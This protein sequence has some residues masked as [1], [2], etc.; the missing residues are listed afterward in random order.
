MMLSK[1][2]FITPLFVVSLLLTTSQSLAS[3]LDKQGSPQIT[4]QIIEIASSDQISKE[5][6]IG[7][8]LSQASGGFNGYIRL[9]WFDDN[10]SA[11]A[12]QIRHELIAKGIV[13][14][15]ITLAYTGGGYR[16]QQASGIQAHVQKIVLQ[17][18]ECRYLTQ[19]YKFS[20][21][22]DTGCALNNNLGSSL[23]SPYKYYF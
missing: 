21:Y 2:R 20:L 18:P 15:R 1:H 14:E 7:K 11:T 4:E 10:F 13:P 3:Q 22:D 19:N 12:K 17:L 8:I 5:I 6:G 16:T 9:E 23:V